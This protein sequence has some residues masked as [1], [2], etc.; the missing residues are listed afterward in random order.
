[1]WKVDNFIRVNSDQNYIEA[2]ERQS[3]QS[4][5]ALDCKIN[6]MQPLTL[7]WSND[8]NVI[9]GDAENTTLQ[10]NNF[11]KLVVNFIGT[12]GSGKG[13]Q[14]AYLTELL[15]IPHISIGDIFRD[16]LLG[17][18]DLGDLIIHHDKTKWPCY[19][20]DEITLGMMVK[21]LASSDCKNGYILDGFPRTIGQA[22]GLL[23]TI[24][25]PNDLHIPIFFDISDDYI[26]DRLKTPRYV[27][28]DCHQQTRVTKKAHQIAQ[29]LLHCESCE[30]KNIMPRE[31]DVNL[32]KL[33]RRLRI[34]SENKLDILGAIRER[35]CIHVLELT[36]EQDP[37]LVFKLVNEIIQKEL[38]RFYGSKKN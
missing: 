8:S 23:N 6:N 27:C 30:S 29:E 37:Q 10:F 17:K 35:D 28:L 31:E 24:L 5:T 20:P 25:R 9:K 14:G 33:E 22:K 13:T 12:S 15:Q 18:T 4:L 36:N 16:D 11:G 34:F 3:S 26:R 2:K 1:M 32:E 19:V 38:S 21:R 7:I